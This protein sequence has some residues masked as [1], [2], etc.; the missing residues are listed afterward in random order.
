LLRAIRTEAAVA[1]TFWFGVS[2]KAVWNWRRAFGVK[3]WGTKGSRRLHK[4]TAEIVSKRLKGVPLDLTP[5]QRQK[6]SRQGKR[7]W[8]QWK[9]TDRRHAFAGR[10]RAPI[11]TDLARDLRETEETNE[12]ANVTE[13]LCSWQPTGFRK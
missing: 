8:K 9:E 4:R 3:Q 13:S 10:S 6:R 2:T 12:A 7:R 11:A 5:K 1:L